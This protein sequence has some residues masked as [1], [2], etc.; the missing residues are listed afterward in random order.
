MVAQDFLTA[1]MGHAFDLL[2]TDGDGVLTEADH[3]LM[4]RRAAKELNHAPQS[5]QEEALVDAYRRAWQ[6]AHQQN[7]DS[8]GKLTRSVYVG[9]V[10]DLFGD[11]ALT[12]QVCDRILDS[13]MDVADVDGK[14]EITPDA[15]R[16]FVLGQSPSLARD[17]VAESFKRIDRN[18]NGVISKSELKQAVVEYFTSSEPQAPGNWLFGPPPVTV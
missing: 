17:D 5:P 1:K 9:S 14:G 3:V 15:Y 11:A 8:E 13:V 16:A 18:G 2:D 4:G 10:R 6:Q 12:D 7:A